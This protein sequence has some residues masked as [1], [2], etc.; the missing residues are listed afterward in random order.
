M[1]HI[2][3][4]TIIAALVLGL[5]SCKDEPA[6]VPEQE[7]WLGADIG[8]CTEYEQKGYKFYNKQGHERECTAL[9]KELGLNAVRHRVWVDPSKHGN[10]CGK[11]DLLVKCRRA[12]QLGMAILLI[13]H[14]SDWWADPAK[15][16]IPAAWSGHSYEQMK[17][18]LAAHTVD[19]LQYLKDNGIEP[20]W[21]QVGNETRNGFLWSVRSNEYGWPV[22]DENGNTEIIESV[23][24]AVRNPQQYAG[25]FAAGYDACKSV[26]PDAIVMVHLDNGFDKDLYDWN[27]GILKKYGAK[28]DMIGMSLY[29]Y[30]ALDGGFRDDEEQTITDCIANIRHVSQKFNS[31]VMIVET[32]FYVDENDPAR[33]EKGR[34]QLAR[35]IRESINE[36]GGRCKGVFYW[37]PECK[38]S[39][40][41]LGAFT[42]GG[43]PTVIMDAFRDWS[44]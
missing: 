37:E 22:V 38:P 36:T 23:G 2:K 32:G 18:D 26:F 25:L 4:L 17:K 40:Y 15:Q 41:K 3:R 5:L 30:W 28:W 6:V 16:N 31:D 39:Q 7:F 24:H 13:F 8:W 21:I 35:V 33:L 1:N 10:W 14:Y 19:I 9:M 11:E 43:Y 29:P 27:L 20:K 42:E 12:D 34:R 44:E